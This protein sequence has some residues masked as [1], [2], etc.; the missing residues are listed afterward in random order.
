MR[1]EAAINI[2]GAHLF[3]LVQAAEVR[4]KG[5]RVI[6]HIIDPDLA[7]AKRYTVT[8]VV[9]VLTSV[10]LRAADPSNRIVSELLKDETIDQEL[11]SGATFD[12]IVDY[13][14]MRRPLRQDPA[15]S[16]QAWQLQTYAW[17]RQQQNPDRRVIAGVLLYLN[18]LVPA[19]A[20]LDQLIEESHATDPHATDMP[21]TGA[22]IA[23]L[24]A[25]QEALAAA[26]RRRDP[27]LELLDEYEA[28]E[29]QVSEALRV[30]RSFRL[31]PINP[32]IITAGL[33]AFDQTVADIEKCVFH[34]SNNGNV[35]N[36]WA[37]RYERRTCVA[38]DFKYQCPVAIEKLKEV[39][40][41]P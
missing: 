35:L 11:M 9:D 12:V 8:G 39:P 24:Q 28:A 19:R 10:E 15:W 30:S 1:A 18:E 13:K 36:A 23:D 4:L 14:G 38:C 29:V 17:L 3:P 26:T 41:V 27:D 16:E 2:W 20:D 34:E 6:P 7:R 5:S 22:D 37:P 21:A 25:L 33:E 32:D 40:T 31:V